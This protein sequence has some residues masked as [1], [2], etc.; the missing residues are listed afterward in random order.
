M[1][2]ILNDMKKKH[3]YTVVGII[4]VCIGGYMFLFPEECIDAIKSFWAL[5][6]ISND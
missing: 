5:G 4:G 2:F 3:F 1:I 6:V